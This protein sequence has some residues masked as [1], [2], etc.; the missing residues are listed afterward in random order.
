ML[1][2]RK[3][4]RE[5]ARPTSDFGLCFVHFDAVAGLREYDGGGEAVGT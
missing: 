5:C 4:E 2:S 3:R 1:K